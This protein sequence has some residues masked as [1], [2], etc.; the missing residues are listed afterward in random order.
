MVYDVVKPKTAFSRSGK[1]SL[2]SQNVTCSRLTTCRVVKEGRA[3]RLEF[4]D[5]ES[6]SVSVEFPFDQAESIIMTLPQML[7][8]ALQRRTRSPSS[9]YVF[10]LG[11]WSIES[12]DARSLIATLSTADGFQVSFSIPFDACRAIGHALRREGEGAMKQDSPSQSEDEPRL[13][14]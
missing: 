5:D 13:L 12:C 2:M 6:R 7:S 3:I 10:S 9:R 4:L 14:N 1:R 11:R 8:K